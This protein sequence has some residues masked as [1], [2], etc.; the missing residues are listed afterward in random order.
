LTTPHFVI[1]VHEHDYEGDD[2]CYCK[3]HHL[4]LFVLT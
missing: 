3:P 2:H 4:N 1:I